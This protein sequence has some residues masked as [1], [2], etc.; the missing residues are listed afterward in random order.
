MFPI[1]VIIVFNWIED[2]LLLNEF[3]VRVH[4]VWKGVPTLRSVGTARHRAQGIVMTLGYKECTIA[5]KGNEP[6]HNALVIALEFLLLLE[7]YSLARY[8]EVGLGT[9]GDKKNATPDF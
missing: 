6:L 1:D 7:G 9:V 4:P 8:P 3:I 5:T 2:I